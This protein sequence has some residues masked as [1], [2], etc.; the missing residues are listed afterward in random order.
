M[1]SMSVNAEAL[2]RFGESLA[3]VGDCNLNM[4]PLEQFQCSPGGLG[5]N[6]TV[7]WRARKSQAQ[8]GAICINVDANYLTDEVMNDAQKVKNFFETF[9]RTN[10][11]LDKNILSKDEDQKALK[12]KR[13]CRDDQTP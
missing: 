2:F 10:I 6:R 7:T 12:D 1:I 8:R 13:H 9:C 4:P 5:S 3:V 11:Q